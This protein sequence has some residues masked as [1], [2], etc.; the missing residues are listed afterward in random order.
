M[1]PGLLA[2]RGREVL[3]K[4]TRLGLKPPR[5]NRLERAAS[6]LE[7]FNA[8][9]KT[10]PLR[11]EQTERQAVLSEAW[12][13]LWDSLLMTHARLEGRA[14]SAA[15]RREHLEALLSGADTAE[16]DRNALFRNLQ[17][18]G[19][20]GARFVLGGT[21]I[22]SAEPDFRFVY[23][24]DKLGLAVKRLTSTAARALRSR[25]K[26]GASQL[27]RSGLRGFI[28]VNLDSWSFDLGGDSDPLSVGKLFEEQ[29][30]EVHQS[31]DV[32]FERDSV[33]GVLVFA[34]WSS[35]TFSDLPRFEWRESARYLL[36]SED[37]T[38]TERFGEF[39]HGAHARLGN[40]L[41]QLRKIV[42][43]D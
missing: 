19:T 2:L 26:E 39:F 7:R 38:E 8:I 14:S 35:W 41:D 28:A 20:V 25:L 31:L 33:L 42:S 5:G 11:V 34:N 1:S 21:A 23:H 13:T 18:E 37:K 29:L 6:T 24:R 15:I 9:A 3:D 4:M 27:S 30:D 16:G 22:E 36:F 32:A 17:F 12:R 10:N 43:P 40:S